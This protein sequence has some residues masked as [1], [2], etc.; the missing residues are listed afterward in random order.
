MLKTL[1]YKRFCGQLRAIGN[2]G[3]K[4]EQGI[5]L[6]REHRAILSFMRRYH[7]QHLIAADARLTFGFLADYNGTT[8]PVA[9][10]RFFELS[11]YGY[12]QQACKISGMRQPRAWSTG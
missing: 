5:E 4:E 8:V 6:T 10:K 11:P 3:M 12:V 1:I 9:R 7:E 2:R